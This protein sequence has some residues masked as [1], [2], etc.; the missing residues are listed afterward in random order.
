MSQPRTILRVRKLLG[1]YRKPGF[2]SE[3]EEDP[4][5]AN[6]QYVVFRLHGNEIYCLPKHPAIQVPLAALMHPHLHP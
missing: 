6:T 3:V 1:Y 4:D 5:H 2:S